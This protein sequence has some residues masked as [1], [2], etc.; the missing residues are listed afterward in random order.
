MR[1]F[2]IS[3][4]VLVYLTLC[5]IVEVIVTVIL[6]RSDIDLYVRPMSLF[7]TDGSEQWG[8]PSL[9]HDKSGRG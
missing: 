2:T 8:L 5:N 6:C 3:A 1:N 9:L 4:T 7:L